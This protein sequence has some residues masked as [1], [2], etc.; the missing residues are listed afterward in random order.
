[1]APYALNLNQY[2][3]QCKTFAVFIIKIPFTIF[4][5]VTNYIHVK[6]KICEIIEKLLRLSENKWNATRR[7]RGWSI[8]QDIPGKE[9]IATGKTPKYDLNTEPEK[10]SPY[11][12]RRRSNG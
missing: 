7:W 5:F 2:H 8:A 10:F 12:H 6:T 3:N 11:N 1:L 4:S 9:H